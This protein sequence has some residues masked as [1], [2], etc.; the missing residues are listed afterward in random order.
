M[1]YL[2][3][4]T[5]TVDAILTKKGRERL[6]EGRTGVDTYSSERLDLGD[7]R[8]INNPKEL[9]KEVQKEY[10]MLELLLII[11]NLRTI[12]FITKK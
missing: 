8:R 9:A 5:I 4:S 11:N 12:N 7:G 6:A 3:N 1:A 2:D 10:V